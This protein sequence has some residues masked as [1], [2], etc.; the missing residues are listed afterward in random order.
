MDAKMGQSSTPPASSPSNLVRYAS[1][2]SQSHWPGPGV[3]VKVEFGIAF[4]PA[5][6]RRLAFE[7]ESRNM[8]SLNRQHPDCLMPGHDDH[9]GTGVDVSSPFQDEDDRRVRRRRIRC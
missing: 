1:D 8:N 7:Y 4:T 6:T 9:L 5:K 2:T 3:F